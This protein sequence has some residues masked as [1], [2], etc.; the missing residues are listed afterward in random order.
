MIGSSQ[1]TGRGA[2]VIVGGAE[3][4]DGDNNILEQFVALARDPR[5]S[6][7]IVICGLASEEPKQMED[8]YGPIFEDLGAQAV[9]LDLNDFAEQ[10]QW[11]T[12]VWITGGDQQRLLDATDQTDFVD[13]LRRRHDEGLVIGGTSAGAAIMST[14]MII[15]A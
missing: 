8:I 15:G 13:V 7:R 6:A 11:A 3:R 2:L 14:T 10:A 1:C 12:A 4:H 9:G 5:E